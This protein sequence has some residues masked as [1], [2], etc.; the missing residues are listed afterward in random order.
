VLIILYDDTG[1][2]AWS[3]FGGKLNMPALKYMDVL[4]GPDTYNHYPTGWAVAFSTPFQMFKRYSNYAGGACDPMVISWPKGIKAKGEI[5]RQYHHSTDIVPTVLDVCGLEMPTTYRGVSNSRSPASP[6]A[7]A[8]TPSLMLPPR[9]RLNCSRQSAHRRAAAR[10]IRLLSG[11]GAGAGRRCREHA[12]SFVQDT[13]ARGRDEPGIRGG[14]GKDGS[15]I[16]VL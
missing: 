13:N 7:P 3:P 11:Y 15:A 14:I 1:L 6:C 2:A 8:L 12:R 5:R 4:G 16:D 9:R 10:E